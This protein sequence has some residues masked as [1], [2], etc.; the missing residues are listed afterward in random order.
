M[1]LLFI[2]INIMYY[3]PAMLIDQF[4]FDFYLNGFLVNLSEL[5]TYIV[6][7][8]IIKKIKRRLFNI[9]GS[10]IAIACS[11]VLIFIHTS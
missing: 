9:I 3:A 5:S 2:T 6:G 11:F 8:F 10:S 7:F 1:M 4:G